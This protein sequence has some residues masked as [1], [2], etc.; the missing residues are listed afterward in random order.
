VTVHLVDKDGE[1]TVAAREEIL[2][3]L[4]GQLGRY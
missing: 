1:P 3:F 4:A 2:G